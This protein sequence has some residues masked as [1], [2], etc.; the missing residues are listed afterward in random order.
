MSKK[1]IIK[2]PSS[3]TI[4]FIFSC[5]SRAALLEVSVSFVTILYSCNPSRAKN[6]TGSICEPSIIKGF[7]SLKHFEIS[8]LQPSRA[9][10]QFYLNC[11]TVSGLLV[12]GITPRF[13]VT[14]L[15]TEVY[16]ILLMLTLS[17]NYVT[18]VDLP[19]HLVPQMRI[20]NG[21]RS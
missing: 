19:I 14:S 11:V 17:A 1:G 3:A 5:I 9:A 21:L 6:S 4:L 2:V 15:T 13:L 12:R 18:S 8:K 10:R 20:T 7:P 16:K